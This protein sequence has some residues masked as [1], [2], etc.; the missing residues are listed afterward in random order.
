ERGQ[1]D[2]AS[3]VA[4]QAAGQAGLAPHQLA[5]RLADHVEAS[6]PPHL[7][8]V[9]VAGPGFLNFF[10]HPSWLHDVLREVVAAGEAYGRGPALAGDRINL[11]FVSLNPTGPIHAGGARWVAVG[12][13][14]AN[15]LAAEGAAVHR[16]YYLN[17]AGGQLDTFGASL[18]ARY[19]GEEPP[20]DGYRGEYL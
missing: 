7:D 1:G 9:E 16:E 13:A 6:P 14:I 18:Y 17:D 4:M 12:D 19:R 5:R 3:P 10:L 8:R 2:W 15:L 20:E 11:E